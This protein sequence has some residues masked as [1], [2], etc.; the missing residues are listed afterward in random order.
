MTFIICPHFVGLGT[1]QAKNVLPDCPNAQKL[2]QSLKETAASQK[3]SWEAQINANQ[4]E[5]VDQITKTGC[6]N[7]APA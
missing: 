5:V 6:P 2:S 1:V 4:Q 3:T 7:M